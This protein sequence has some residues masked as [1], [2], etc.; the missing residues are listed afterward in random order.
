MKRIITALMG[1]LLFCSCDSK[2]EP[3]KHLPQLTIEQLNYTLGQKKVSIKLSA[4]EAPKTDLTVPVTFTG[5][6]KLNEDFELENSAFLLKA[7][8]TSALLEIKRKGELSENP[9]KV[10][11]SLGEAPA[12]YE[13]GLKNYCMLNLLGKDGF[14]LNFTQT[15]GELGFMGAFGIHIEAIK[16]GKY[17]LKTESRFGIVVDPAST[18]V[19]GEHFDLLDDAQAIVPRKRNKGIFKVKFLKKEDGK[20]KIILRFADRDGFAPGNNEK[21]TITI[22]GP[23]DINGNWEFTKIANGDWLMDPN[24][25]FGIELNELLDVQAGDEIKLEGD[26]FKY[27]LTPTLTGKLKNFFTNECELQIDSSREDHL[28]EGNNEK[29]TL[30]R[31]KTEGVN[32]LF[33]GSETKKRPA[34]VDFRLIK[35]ENDQEILECTLADF[36]PTTADTPTWK[37]L[38]EMMGSMEWTPLRLHFKRK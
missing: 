21:I 17:R 29:I 28:Q 18:A 5:E 26:T 27:K 10:Q 16:G 24:N 6:A 3:I 36:E 12:G 32:V 30:T 8:E 31:Y 37:T 35:D 22:K 11:I 7:G 23:I 15:E 20:D 38:Y 33:S 1:I 25:Y 2:E 4:Q 13:I 14:L 34:F 19:L 9:K